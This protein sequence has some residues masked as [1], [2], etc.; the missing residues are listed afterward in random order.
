MAKQWALTPQNPV[1]FRA[2][3]HMVRCN[4]KRWERITVIAKSKSVMKRVQTQAT[5]EGWEI[6]S[7]KM[8]DNDVIIVLKKEAK[9]A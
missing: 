8:Q 6:D 3:S 7:V 9:N 5:A 1:R 2:V 4:M